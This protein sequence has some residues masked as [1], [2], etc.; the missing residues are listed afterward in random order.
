M[1]NDRV[2]CESEV[3]QYILTFDE[4]YEID[5]N[6]LMVDG[7][8]FPKTTLTLKPLET[9]YGGNTSYFVVRLTNGSESTHLRYGTESRAKK[10]YKEI[11]DFIAH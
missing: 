11:S 6:A 10:V 1:S 4:P 9:W 2:R 3:S 7:Y 8:V 5:G